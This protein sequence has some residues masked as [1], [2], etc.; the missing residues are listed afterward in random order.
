MFKIIKSQQTLRLLFSILLIILMFFM[1]LPNDVA[2]ETPNPGDFSS[3]DA[4]IEAQMEKHGLPGVAI[5]IVDG[6]DVVYSQGFGRAGRD[7]SMTAEMQMFIGSQ[8]K[9]FTALAVAQLAEQGLLDLDELVQTY[10]PWFRVADET[11]SGQITVRHLLTHSSGLSDAG[12]PV[13]LTRDT[14]LEEAVRALE[15]ASL[16]AL[17]GSEFQYF[18]RGYTVLAYL[19]EIRSGQPFADYVRDQIMIPLGMENSTADSGSTQAIAQGYSRLFG[20]NFPMP[21]PTPEYGTGAA[22]MVST[23]EDLAKFAIA[24]NNQAEALVS[25]M[26]GEEIFT[27][28]LG[29]YGF[30]WWIVDD[31]DKAFHGGADETFRTDVNLYPQQG[32]AFVLLVNQGHQF[33]HFVSAMQLLDSVEA[34]VLGSAPIPVG[35]GWSV[36]WLGWG[37]GIITLGLSIMHVHN[38]IKLRSWPERAKNMSKRKR[39]TD[40]GLSFLIPTVILVIVLSQVRAF[41]GD[42]F[43]LWP[44]LVGMPRIIPDVFILMLVAAIPDYVQGIIKIILWQRKPKV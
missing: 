8:S 24:M 28:G 16:T 3:L 10:I 11:A 5:A 36:R 7:R 40:I 42:R 23:V 14:S 29:G 26:M 39:L 1:L 21:Q 34:F 41:Y 15:R 2:A 33:D 38:F 37:V 43:N 44:T 13:V 17:V 31:G 18:N 30:G 9:S 22:N 25:P 27:P 19:V 35:E 12:F 6:D 20:F 4:V 32:L